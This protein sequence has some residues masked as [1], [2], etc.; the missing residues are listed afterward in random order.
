MTEKK[1]I[2]T[3]SQLRELEIQWTVIGKE[4]VTLKFPLAPDL[5]AIKAEIKERIKVF[6]ELIKETNPKHDIYLQL[7]CARGEL[8]LLLSLL[9][10]APD[11]NKC[12]G[13]CKCGRPCAVARCSWKSQSA[14]PIKDCDDEH[15]H[16]CG[17]CLLKKKSQSPPSKQREGKK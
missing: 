10:P 12:K 5:D 9:E 8:V 2:I 6:D 1:Y 15:E 17:I 4:K 14:L 7:T 16:I 3:E 11:D 13:I